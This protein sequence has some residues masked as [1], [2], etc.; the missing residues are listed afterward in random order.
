MYPRH[1]IHHLGDGSDN[2]RN[3]R[4]ADNYHKYRI[5]VHFVTEYIT[6][7]STVLPILQDPSGGFQQAINYLQSVLS[8]IRVDH[9][10]T[11]SPSCAS[12]NRN[13]QCTRLRSQTCGQ[14]ATVPYEHYETTMVCDPTCREIGGGV[15]ADY[16]FYVS[17][18]RD[19][20]LYIITF[21]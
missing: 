13:G 18:I 6:D 15:D 7:S 14:F 12:R 9:N 2:V 1:P 17:S 3:R 19:S 20:K 21:L 10:L 5:A 4:K 11:I 16:I 8:V